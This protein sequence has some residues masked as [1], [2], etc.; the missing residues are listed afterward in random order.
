MTAKVIAPFSP[1]GLPRFM[2]ELAE[3]DK[4]VLVDRI[5]VRAGRNARIDMD[6]STFYRAPGGVQ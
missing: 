4:T 3:A 6:I 2:A 5:S 1:D